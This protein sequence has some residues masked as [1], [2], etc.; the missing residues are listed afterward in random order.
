MTDKQRRVLWEI[1]TE[2]EKARLKFDKMRGP[3]E[4]Y[5]VILEELDEMWDDIKGNNPTG[6]RKEAVQIGAMVLAF[7]L[8]VCDADR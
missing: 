6:M 4:G 8:E 3:H 1:Q 2:Y 7:I 5:A